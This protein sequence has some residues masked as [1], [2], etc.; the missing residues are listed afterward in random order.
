[1]L[2][3]PNN[4]SIGILYVRPTVEIIRELWINDKEGLAPLWEKKISGQNTLKESMGS[5]M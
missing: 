1:M 2:L 3:N 4:V 5:L